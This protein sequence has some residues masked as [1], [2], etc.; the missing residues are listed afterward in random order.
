[1]E[2]AKNILILGGYGRTGVELARLLLKESGHN[3]GLAGRDQIK[4]IRSARELNWEYPGQRVE[5]VQV[6]VAFRRKLTDIMTDYDLA[7]ASVRR[8]AFGGQM[9]MAALDAS[10]NYVDLNPDNDRRKAI[11]GLHE[12]VRRAGL[13]FLTQAGFVPGARELMA[14]YAASYFDFPEDV[15]VRIFDSPSNERHTRIALTGL[16][17][18]RMK[19]LGMTIEHWDPHLA[20]AITALPCILGLLDGSLKE[21]GVH[22]M[23]H[24]MDPD[25]A[26]ESLWDRN[27]M[28]SLEGLWDLDQEDSQPEDIGFMEQV[29]GNVI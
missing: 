7:V 9:A 18:G 8:T 11:E 13:T 26:L 23:G 22:A 1:M 6:N 4:A 21:V 10:V 20:T 12:E 19:T 15:V 16:K 25:R 27:M 28:V 5:A 2:K 24:V 3:I 29:A 17:A 14:R